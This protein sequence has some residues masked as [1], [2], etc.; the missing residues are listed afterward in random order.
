MTLHISWLKERQHRVKS[1]WNPIQQ[2]IKSHKM[3]VHVGHFASLSCGSTTQLI[4]AMPAQPCALLHSLLAL[5]VMYLD[6][7]VCLI[8]LFNRY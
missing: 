2:T 7:L 1:C 4:I 3:L 8:F 6:R 5:F